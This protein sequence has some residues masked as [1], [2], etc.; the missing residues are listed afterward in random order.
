MV[1]EMEATERER[2]RA[3][4]E[5]R[6]AGDERS[7]GWSRV[8]A[9]ACGALALAT[10]IG[11]VVLWPGAGPSQ[12]G[13]PALGGPTL[14]A[15]AAGVTTVDC[16]GPVAQPCVEL[17]VRLRS[18]RAAAITLGPAGTVRAPKAGTH[19]RVRAAGGE[20]TFAGVDRRRAL[21]VLALIFAVLVV[22]IARARGLLAL[23]GLAIS[24]AL[25]TR[26]VLPALLAGESG[27]LVAVVGSLA[28]MFVTVV[29][30]YGLSPP[31]LA[32]CLGI[33]VSLLFAAG[34]GTVAVKATALDGGL[35]ELTA[36]L[37]G[38]GRGISM[39]GLVLA[40][41]VVGAL[42]VLADTG[43]TQASAVMALRRANPA[44]SARALFHGAFTVGRDHLVATTHTLVLAYLGASLPLLLGLGAGGV[45]P[46]DAL[47]SQDV[48]EPI[49]ATL[50]GAIALLVSV[51]LT[52][53]LCVA[54]AHR[55]PVSALGGAEA[56][57]HAH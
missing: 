21:L 9:G 38:S 40:G 24:I 46:T 15:V 14:P 10:L 47:N 48:A 51:P 3:E 39:Q 4:R 25:V 13:G 33:G 5:R 32:A 20:Y 16:G 22:A 29:L 30:T 19:V 41:L 18:G 12:A 2:R 49:V 7:A 6:R 50:V 53:A 37:A 56:H 44:L 52:T 35:G 26:F 45:S 27:L 31:S 11:L 54:V 42:G 34:A 43:V 17:H 8:L 36:Y 23:A 55:M 28:V 57:A 1:S